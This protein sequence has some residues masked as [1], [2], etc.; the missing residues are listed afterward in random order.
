MIYSIQINS[1]LFRCIDLLGI[2]SQVGETHDRT[3]RNSALSLDIFLF[4]FPRFIMPVQLIR[5]D[6]TAYGPRKD[7][8]SNDPLFLPEKPRDKEQLITDYLLPP[9]SIINLKADGKYI[10]WS[11]IK[12]VNDLEIQVLRPHQNGNMTLLSLCSPLLT[13]FMLI[14]SEAKGQKV[15]R[16]R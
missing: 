13:L 8:E 14:N 12:D 6:L 7:G 10:P 4:L 16:G 1:I 11:L 9:D 15:R 5:L 3:G 2:G